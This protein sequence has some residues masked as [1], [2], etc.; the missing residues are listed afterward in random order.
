[1]GILEHER[2]DLKQKTMDLKG[3]AWFAQKKQIS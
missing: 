1:M 3:N 2:Q